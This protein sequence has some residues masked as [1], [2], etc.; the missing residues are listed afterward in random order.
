MDGR[1]FVPHPSVTVGE[2]GLGDPDKTPDKQR[3]AGVRREHSRL[4]QRCSYVNKG[5]LLSVV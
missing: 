1:G 3:A 5:S 4:R 2:W